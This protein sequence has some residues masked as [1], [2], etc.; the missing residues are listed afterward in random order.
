MDPLW[1]DRFFPDH[2]DAS[3]IQQIDSSGRGFDPDPD[4]GCPRAERDTFVVG[5][6]Q[7]SDAGHSMSFRIAPPGRRG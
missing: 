1:L 7:M 2:Y 4:D 6:D 3:D 5:Y